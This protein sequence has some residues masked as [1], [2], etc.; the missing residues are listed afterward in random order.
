MNR[1]IEIETELDDLHNIENPITWH[2]DN[3]SV[4]N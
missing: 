2:K 4:E 1:K 3:I